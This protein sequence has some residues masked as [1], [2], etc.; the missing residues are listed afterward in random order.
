MT[1]Y[2]YQ[3]KYNFYQ[4]LYNSFR[5]ININNYYRDYD[6]SKRKFKYSLII[7][8]SNNHTLIMFKL[9]DYFIILRKYLLKLKTLD[10]VLAE[11]GGYNKWIYY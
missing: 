4:I 11:K 7:K 6:N 8:N 2:F 1:I 9:Y 3:T 5:R 10:N